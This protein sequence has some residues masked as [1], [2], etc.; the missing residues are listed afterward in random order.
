M[1][2]YSH[3][4]R[5]SSDIF[6]DYTRANYG[7]IFLKYTGAQIWNDLPIDLK[8][9]EILL[10]NSFKKSAIVYVQNQSILNS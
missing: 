7:K 2:T 1:R 6:I 8:K 3:A 10:I 9:V 4:T 5:S